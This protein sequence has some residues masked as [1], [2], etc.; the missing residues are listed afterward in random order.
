MDQRSRLV[1]FLK[2]AFVTSVCLLEV[3]MECYSWN[4]PLPSA[5]GGWV[6]GL[7]LCTSLPD[8]KR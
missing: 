5:L 8:S 4:S 6:L 7:T 3:C 1:T 2:Y